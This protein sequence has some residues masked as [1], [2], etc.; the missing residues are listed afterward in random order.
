MDILK[1]E[2]EKI[3]PSELEI[4]ELDRKTKDIIKSIKD[5]FKKQGIVADVFIG[6]SSAKNT[7][8]KKKKYDV[9][10]F[11]RFDKKYDENKISTLLKKALPKNIKIV[12]GS[13]DY[14]SLNYEGVDFEVVPV[15]KINNPKQATNVTD[16]SYFHVNYVKKHIN[17]KLKLADEIRLAKS[18]A[19]GADCYGAESYINGF[20]GYALELLIIYYGSF[21]KFIKEMSK[22]K[23]KIVVDSAKLYKNKKHI[24]NEMNDSKL[25]S[26]IIFI[27]PT[28][29]ER[30]ALAAL[31]PDTFKKF[32]VFCKK[33]LNKP[34]LKFFDIEDKCEVLEK[35]YRKSLIKIKINT[36]RQAGDIAG[37]KLKKFSRYF[38]RELEKAFDIKVKD[39]D[40]NEK[41]NFGLIF[42][43]AKPKK[44]V[45]ICGPPV[46]MIK[47]VKAF[48]KEHKK[49][50][51][52]KG[53]ICF[54]KKLNYNLK[55]YI[56]GFVKDRKK[57][58]KQMGVSFVGLEN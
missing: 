28:F 58:L 54:V 44:E 14:F 11:V 56:K 38:I 26:P 10:L 45:L 13:R 7:L 24:L 52:K 37:T 35:K 19:H 18:F 27:D 47:A 41:E 39:F 20:S 12:H 51:V 49:T 40:Y 15:F 46:K 29:K 17:K 9:D 5:K 57:I 2:L 31:S 33:F 43:V 22:I 55:D 3:K 21:V 4:Q 48:K 53:K 36:D 23:D 1:K 34:S 8:I 32:Q 30:N 16:L 50:I 25:H 42:L 6:G